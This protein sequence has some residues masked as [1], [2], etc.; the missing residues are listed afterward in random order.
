MAIQKKICMLGLFSVGKTSLVKRYVES[1]FSEKYQTTVGVK[2]DKKIV[3]ANGKEVTLVL[4]DL[5]GKDGIT[6]IRES[7]LRGSSGYILVADGT[8]EAS[9][10]TV[11]QIHEAYIERHGVPFILVINKYD[12]VDDWVIDESVV[13]SFVEEGWTVI[14]TSAKYDEMVDEAFE[15]LTKKMLEKPATSP[16]GETRPGAV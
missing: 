8:R 16:A 14:K 11:K 5:A 4:W 9:I 10:D 7:Y 15:V 6:D 12:L 13:D 2:I 3:K 1:I